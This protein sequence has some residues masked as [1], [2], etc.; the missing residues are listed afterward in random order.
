MDQVEILI[1]KAEEDIKA[2]EMLLKQKFYRIA[3]SRSY[4]A[5]FYIV[6]A[7]L[8]TKNLSYSSH[9]AVISFFGKE[10][11]KTKIFNPKFGFILRDTFDLR[12]NGDYESLPDINSNKAKKILSDAKEFLKAAKKYLKKKR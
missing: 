5:M 7:I 10:F 3:V 4:Y 12:Q 2:V 8:L 6:E 1:R 11:I 9:R